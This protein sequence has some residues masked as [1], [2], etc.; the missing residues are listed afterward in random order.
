MTEF[1]QDYARPVWVPLFVAWLIALISTVG[2]LF[3]GEVLGQAPCVLCWYQ[4][5]FMFPLALILGVACYQSDTEVWRYALPLA[6][7]GGAIAGY[8][9]ALYAGVLP[10]AIEPCGEGPSCSSAAMTVFG[11]VPIP[12][13]S[14]GAFAGI[15]L[16]LIIA[17]RRTLS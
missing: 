4:R 8:H 11:G 1:P 16:L 5:I 9:S 13:L 12:Y 6:T 14:L 17:H 15:V 2:A 3:V 10:V 7:I